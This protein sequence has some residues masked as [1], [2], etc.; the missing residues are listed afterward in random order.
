VRCGVGHANQRAEPEFIYPV[1]AKTCPNWVY[2]FKHRCRA[3]ELGTVV[4]RTTSLLNAKMVNKR[5]LTAREGQVNDFFSYLAAKTHEEVC[6]FYS[7]SWSK[8]E[9]SSKNQKN[10]FLSKKKSFVQKC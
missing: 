2:K 10:C 8:K 5:K 4:E 7:F 6:S 9:T 1:L 3:W